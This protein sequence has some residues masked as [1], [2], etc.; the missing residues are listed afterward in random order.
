M[1]TKLQIAKHFLYP[2]SLYVS[3]DPHL[4]TTV[5]GSCI[6][7]CLFD[8]KEKAGGINHYMLPLWNGEGLAS[9][10]FGNIAIEKLIEEMELR[11][12]DRKN[13]YAKLFGGASQVNYSM[14]IGQRNIE[15][16]RKLLIENNINIVAESV[17]GSQGRK[18]IFN[19]YTGEVRMK[20]VSSVVNYNIQ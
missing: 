18:I 6:A 19:T 15:I 11:G 8:P 1:T 16:A 20:Y 12:S 9:V 10:K 14:Q 4:V 5:L 2:S 3:R 17:G 7:V 13:L